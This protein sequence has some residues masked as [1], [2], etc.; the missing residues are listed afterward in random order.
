MSKTALDLVGGFGAAQ[1]GLESVGLVYFTLRLE[2]VGRRR[3]RINK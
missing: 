1:R 3:R 2:V